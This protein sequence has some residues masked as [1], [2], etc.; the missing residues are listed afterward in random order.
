MKFIKYLVLN[1]LVVITF[2][3]KDAWEDH[4]NLNSDVSDKTIVQVIESRPEL[5]EFL[6]YL[7][8]S[9]LDKELES[10]K[11]YTL[12]IPDN[13]AMASVDQT[14]LNDSAKL[15]LFVSNHFAALEYT[16]QGEKK[17]TSVKAYNGKLLVFNNADS[18][19]D[20]YK[21]KKGDIIARNG[22]VHIVNHVLN[23]RLNI[24]EYIENQATVNEHVNY[25][26]S[27]S[28]KVF[29]ANP[30][31]QTGFDPITG[32][33]VYD[34]A[35]C[36]VWHNTFLDNVADL[37]VEDSVYTVFIVDD[38]VYDSEYQRFKKYFVV[39]TG[40]AHNDSVKIKYKIT[41]DY[42]FRGAYKTP[43]VPDTLKSLSD[44]KVPF[45]GS[46]TL[47]YRASNGYVY[48]VSDCSIDLHNKIP[49]IIVEAETAN[50]YLLPLISV[51]GSNKRFNPLASGGFDFILDNHAQK[52]A[53]YADGSANPSAGGFALFVKEVASIKYKISWKAVNDFRGGLRTPNDTLT[54]KQKLAFSQIDHF[55]GTQ[56]VWKQASLVTPSY[57]KITDHSYATA[58]EVELAKWT[59]SFMREDIYFQILC[60]GTNMSVTLDYLKLEPIFE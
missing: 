32:K 6:I 30:L 23:P 59:F 13:D 31:Y 25:L 14:I 37:R 39:E 49:T 33:P 45:K 35:K 54:L 41:K 36:M 4:I 5:S 28:G 50:K 2:S 3:C 52:A 10:S 60:G 47:L 24:W 8:K 26:K 56:P 53:E 16:I 58:Q 27:L 44:V 17:E 19:I 48:K 1:L 9:G 29:V 57:V 38:N 43:E 18:T 15:S 55:T 42:V 46:A 20:G 21:I 51:A 22:I 40:S 7:K 11:M 34:M 12:W